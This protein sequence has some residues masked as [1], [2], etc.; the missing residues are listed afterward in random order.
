MGHVQTRSGRLS[1]RCST[2]SAPSPSAATSH[3]RQPDQ[4]QSRHRAVPHT[5]LG[6]V[7]ACL[8]ITRDDRA[9]P[10]LF[11]PSR[12]PRSGMVFSSQLP[13]SAPFSMTKEDIGLTTNPPALEPQPV[14]FFPQWSFGL[15]M[16]TFISLQVIPPRLF[17]NRLHR[18]WRGPTSLTLVGNSAG[19]PEPILR[20]SPAIG[21]DTEILEIKDPYVGYNAEAF[22]SKRPNG[23]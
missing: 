1:R 19:S 15:H 13:G 12:L 8:D 16:V 11:L 18:E 7:F 14:A 4:T 21:H 23:R 5:S 10:P 6:T 9:R 17:H 3:H 2:G 20:P 22:P